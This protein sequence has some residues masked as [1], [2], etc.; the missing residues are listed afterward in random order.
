MSDPVVIRLDCPAHV[1]AKARYVFDTLL[2]ARRVPVAYDDTGDRAPNVVY[3]AEF[4]QVPKN[5]LGVFCSARAWDFFGEAADVGRAA[6]VQG[7]RVVFDEFCENPNTPD[8]ISFDLVANAF[9]FLSSWS[10]RVPSERDRGTRALYADSVFR[11]LDIPQTVVDDY[12]S[13]LM[14]ALSKS[15][16]TVLDRISGTRRW[17][18]GSA[19]AV[20]ISHDEDFIPRNLADTITMGAKSV[21]R[22]L[23]THRS[24]MDAIRVAGAFIGSL[25]RGRNPY[26]TVPELVRKEQARGVRASYQIAV[27]NR[28]PNDVTYRIE[29]K[30]V[31]S[32]LRPIVDA[33]F[34]V[35]LH[36]SYRS[37]ERAEWYA[38]EVRT[39][40]EHFAQPRGSRQHY[41]SFDYDTLFAAQEHAGIA[42]DMSIGYPDACGSRVGFSHP[43]HPYNLAEDRPYRVLEIPLVL[44]DVTLRTYLGLSA[45]D[46]RE[47]IKAE[48][49]LL[50]RAG[51]CGSIVWHPILF[52]GARDPG[53]DDLYWELIDLTQGLGGWA[54][55]ARSIHD[56]LRTVLRQY[57][58][59][60]PSQ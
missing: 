44:M 25:A 19:F 48:L 18:D 49:E 10:E 4:A 50:R 11:R 43:Y 30:A 21:L 24:P 15:A 27:A 34:D 6:T 8:A 12:A 1:R 20:V 47:R 59:F 7:L 22:Q 26:L 2:A 28:H 56:A 29:D 3:T 37:T 9:Y 5:A 60:P 32:Y 38:D 14:G 39:L 51:G 31:Q 40:T 53:F 46:A 41:L 13:L 16:P 45:P 33:G 55:D 36:G 23:I 17:L 54:G 57:P 42:Y 35:C 52:G 58:S